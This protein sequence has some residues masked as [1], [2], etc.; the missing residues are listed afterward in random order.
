MATDKLVDKQ[1]AALKPKE[2]PYKEADGGGLYVFVQPNGSK[3]WRMAYRFA[4]K[5]KV[6]A[7]GAYPEVTLAEARKRRDE[8][9]KL[10]RD[11]IDPGAKKAA[12]KI[13][14]KIASKAFGDWTDE[15]LAK[16]KKSGLDAR[17]IVTK[18]RFAG[19]LKDEFGRVP[20]EIISKLA[21]L[22]FL[23]KLEDEGKLETR[24]RLRSIGEQIF[25]FADLEGSLRNPFRG[26]KKQ[27]VENKATPRPAL[28]NVKSGAVGQ[29]FKDIAADFAGARFGDAAGKALRFMS[30]TA[31]RPGEIASAEWCDFDVEAK[32]W[33]IPAEKMKMEKEHIVPLSRHSRSWRR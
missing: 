10:L 23:R 9:R 8:A 32:L 19:Y 20:L 1:V 4:D 27:L 17:T 15:W 33:T 2:A 3:L 11:G 16:E 30:L 31:V 25:D 12:D 18:T 28:I 14:Q 24:D 29:L 7:F 5:Q 26:L 21:V 6:L 22:N 13:A